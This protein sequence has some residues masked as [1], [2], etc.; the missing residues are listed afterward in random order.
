MKRMSKGSPTGLVAGPSALALPRSSCGTTAAAR[1][2]ASGGASLASQFCT[3]THQVPAA[4]SGISH[5][6]NA[7]PPA[8]THSSVAELG[9]SPVPT[10]RSRSGDSDS[11]ISAMSRRSPALTST[12]M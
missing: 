1:V 2:R 7:V 5:S 12:V 3:S 9:V 10:K 8:D 11:R 6:S 4:G